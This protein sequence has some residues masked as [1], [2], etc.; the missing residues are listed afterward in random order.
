MKIP[1]RSSLLQDI[2]RAAMMMAI[3]VALVLIIPRIALAHAVLV[4]SSPLANAIVQGPDVPVTM[5]FNSRVDGSRSTLLLSTPDGQSKP[6]TIDKQSAPDTLTTRATG[7]GAGEYAIHWQ[8]L[9]TDGHI[10]RGQI[11]FAVK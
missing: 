2:F 10:T 11:P 9:A 8:V 1:G 5:K 7:L 6:L 4:Q 3:A